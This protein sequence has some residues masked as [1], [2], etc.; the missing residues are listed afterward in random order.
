MASNA[1]QICSNAV[2]T[3]NNPS[4]ENPTWD[5]L[6][7]N[8]N[9]TELQKQ[10]RKLGAAS[11]WVTKEKLVDMIMAKHYSLNPRRTSNEDPEVDPILKL[12]QDIKELK[13]QM[14][15]KDSEIE[16]LN[17][18]VQ[19]AQVTINKMNDRITT[20]E[21]E[22]RRRDE[23]PTAAGQASTAQERI[24]LIG[25]ENLGEAQTTDFQSD[26]T[27]RTIPNAT[28]D[29]A[30]C[31]IEEKLNW[32]PHKCILYCGIHDL[33]DDENSVLILDKLESLVSTLKSRD[34]DIEIYVSELVPSL[35]EGVK[36][37][38]DEYNDKLNEWGSANGVTVIKSS[39]HFK[40][41]SGEIDVTC[42]KDSI[43]NSE[44]TLNR[45]GMIR[46]LSA[47]KGQC[48]FLKVNVTANKVNRRENRLPPVHSDRRH[49]QRYETYYRQPAS[50][51]S[52]AYVQGHVA[53]TM[54]MQL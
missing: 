30:R 47:M 41:C 38:V 24:L 46:L 13:D 4:L 34:E 3:N 20:L 36:V 7:N 23:F 2:E 45:H 39:V 16:E 12:Q 43:G 19:T 5:Y 28:M 51:A 29:L 33:L 37:L 32:T 52:V 14:A 48:N 49:A 31:W 18:I 53:G 25:D 11:V 10:C 27:I 44:S 6:F 17:V 42:F 35:K 15:M 1:E 22:L 54:R 26:C 8:Y 21:E 50:G 40:Y 9:K